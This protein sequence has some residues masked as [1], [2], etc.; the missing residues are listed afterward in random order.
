VRKRK[1]RR[2]PDPDHLGD[3]QLWG[4][5]DEDG[6]EFVVWAES[7]TDPDMQEAVEKVRQVFRDQGFTQLAGD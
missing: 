6:D 2:G 7:T 3:L 4:A 1:R 5:V